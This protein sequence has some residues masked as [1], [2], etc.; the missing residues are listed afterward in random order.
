MRF[1]QIFFKT[2]SK[3]LPLSM[4]PKDSKRL[5]PGY[6]GVSRR[7]GLAQGEALPPSFAAAN[8][9]GQVAQASRKPRRDISEGKQKL[10]GFTAQNACTVVETQAQSK[11]LGP[12]AIVRLRR[13]IKQPVTPVYGRNDN[14][15]VA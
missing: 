12:I 10:R 6:A 14:F 2:F 13:M 8:Y 1:A 9:G 15:H 5:A 3:H 4:L 11:L 7:S